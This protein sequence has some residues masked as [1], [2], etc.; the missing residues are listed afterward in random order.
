MVNEEEMRIRHPAP[1]ISN[2]EARAYLANE[3]GITKQCI[4]QLD[5]R[6]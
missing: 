6:T 2:D 5:I 3:V 1:P 4:I